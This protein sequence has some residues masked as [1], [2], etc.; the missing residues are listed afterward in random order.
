MKVYLVFCGDEY[1]PAGF[2]DYQGIFANYYLAFSFLSEK[3]LKAIKF[4]RYIPGYFDW[5]E[6]IEV[7]E[8][9]SKLVFRNNIHF[10]KGF[11]DGDLEG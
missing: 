9:E 10:F 8:L 2:D 7:T 1:Y 3:A 6:I 5:A 11:K 4:G